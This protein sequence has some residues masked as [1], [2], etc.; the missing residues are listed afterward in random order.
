VACGPRL[1]LKSSSDD[2]SD[3]PTGEQA[4]VDFLLDLLRSSNEKLVISIVGSARVLT[5]A[6][7][8][9]PGL[10]RS[11]TELVLLNAG[12]TGG[13]KREWNVDLD[14]SAYVGL[15]K[16][17]LPIWW[18]PCSTE[19]GAFNSDNDRG[20]YWKAVQ[21]LLLRDLAPSVRTWFF[22][23]LAGKHTGNG[24]ADWDAAVDGAEWQRLLTME[25]SMWSTASLVMT[26]GRVLAKTG[27]GWRFVRS[28]HAEGED[29]WKWRMDEI[30]AE[31][32]PDAN[33][34]WSLCGSGGNAL[35]FGRERRAGFGNAMGEALGSLLRG[36]GKS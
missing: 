36:V 22:H 33:V 11:R 8:R 20:T 26:A 31:V 15:W 1:P 28:D 3:R 19:A 29:V 34:H 16:S 32:D 23:V 12:S 35:L 7:N 14:S 5:A 18:F 21:Q 10:L 9:D 30:C 17:G 6:F 27:E 13:P 4:G 2:L 25:R 24:V